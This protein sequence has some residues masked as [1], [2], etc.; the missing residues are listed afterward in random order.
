M[1][2]C[3]A[4]LFLVL[5]CASRPVRAPAPSPASLRV[6]VVTDFAP[7]RVRAVRVIVDGALFPEATPIVLAEG[8]HVATID[9]DIVEPCEGTDEAHR[10]IHVRAATIV[11]TQSTGTGLRLILKARPDAAYLDARLAVSGGSLAPPT[12]DERAQSADAPVAVENPAVW[13]DDAF[14]HDE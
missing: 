5:G 1:R 7:T 13:I 11:Y 3:V 14:C 8:G 4:A 2:S 9:V 12:A 6:D 10:R